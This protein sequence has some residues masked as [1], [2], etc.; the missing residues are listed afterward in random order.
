MQNMALRAA[1][2]SSTH[3]RVNRYLLP[4]TLL[5]VDHRGVRSCRG[6]G[7]QPFLQSHRRW[8]SPWTEESHLSYGNEDGKVFFACPIWMRSHR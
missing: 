8:I 4:R 2:R 7:C 6:D 3:H 1:S 5:Q